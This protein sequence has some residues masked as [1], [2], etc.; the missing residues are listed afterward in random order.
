VLAPQSFGID[1]MLFD[2]DGKYAALAW[3]AI[4]HSYD[5]LRERTDWDT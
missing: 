4:A 2:P 1:A 3:P 5:E